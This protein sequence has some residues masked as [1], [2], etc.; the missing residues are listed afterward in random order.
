MALVE[1]VLQPGY[2]YKSLIKLVLFT[3]VPL[4]YALACKDPV[5]INLFHIR[6]KP[7]L[8]ALALGIGVYLFILAS[9]F[10]L[11]PYFDFSNVTKSLEKSVGVD[12]H[13]FLAVA[14]YISL[15]NSLL[16]EF[17]FRGFAFLT[18]KKLASR[19]FSYLFSAS[20]FSLYHVAIMSNWFSVILFLLLV[21]S[22]FIAGLIFNRLDEHSDSIYPSWI[23]H[24]FANLSI[25]TIGLMLFGIL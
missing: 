16:E 25:N 8:R 20:T 2:L 21:F 17:F 10:L 11:G 18:M 23:F 7:L 4:I 9:Y 1:T 6:R 19:R 3:S 22:L 5:I 13:S 15:I 14:I 24:A 12:R